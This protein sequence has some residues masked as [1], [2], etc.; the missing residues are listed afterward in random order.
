[1]KIFL[2]TWMKRY[3]KLGVLITNFIVTVIF[4]VSKLHN[5]I[6]LILAVRSKKLF[7]SIFNSVYRN[8]SIMST[9]MWKKMTKD[10]KEGKAL[11]E[12][13]NVGVREEKQD[14]DGNAMSVDPPEA[15]EHQSLSLMDNTFALGKRSEQIIESSLLLIGGVPCDLSASSLDSEIGIIARTIEF[16]FNIGVDFVALETA[17]TTL[18]KKE[19]I[20]YTDGD[21]CSFT[22]SLKEKMTFNL[23]GHMIFPPAFGHCE[24]EFASFNFTCQA[25]PSLSTHASLKKGIE[26]AIFRWNLSVSY[27]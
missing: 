5:I 19:L 7:F 2:N 21:S 3:N 6:V 9:K 8:K 11:D 20:I 24:T 16:M 1:M 4:V 13:L 26:L 18:S 10:S 27:H 15:L 12:Y 14:T 23:G 17:L 25:I 22:L